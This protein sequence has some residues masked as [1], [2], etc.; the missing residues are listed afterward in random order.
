MVQIGHERKNHRRQEVRNFSLLLSDRDRERM[1]A[2]V[3]ISYGPL[4]CRVRSKL[5]Y[6]D[7]KFFV[8]APEKNN[9]KIRK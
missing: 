9:E 5:I 1:H 2:T 3:W 8:A 6:G 7:I 4:G